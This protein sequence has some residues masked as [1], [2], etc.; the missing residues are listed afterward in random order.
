MQTIL[1]HAKGVVIIFAIH[2]NAK[3]TAW[4]DVITNRRGKTLEEFLQ[5][6]QLHIAKE[7]SCCTMFRTC[8]GDSNIDLTVLNNRAIDFISDWAV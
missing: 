4:H 3:S 6:R 8:R 1:T 7:G 5:S 2:S